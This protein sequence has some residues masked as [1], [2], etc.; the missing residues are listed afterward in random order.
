MQDVIEFYGAWVSRSDNYQHDR[1]RVMRL[2]AGL[3]LG[4]LAWLAAQ[5]LVRRRMRRPAVPPRDRPVPAP[6]P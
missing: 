3:P 2:L 1:A 6:E 4:L 5:T